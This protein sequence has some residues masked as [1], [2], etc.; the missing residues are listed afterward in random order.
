MLPDCSACVQPREDAEVISN[1][2]LRSIDELASVFSKR[3]SN[4]VL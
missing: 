1:S 3:Q 2:S 4:R